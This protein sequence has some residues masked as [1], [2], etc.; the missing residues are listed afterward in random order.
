VA[1][2]ALAAV[3]GIGL[4]VRQRTRA[5]AT[6]A[7]AA[8]ASAG[9]RVVPVSVTTVARRD[10]PIFLEG[11]GSVAA[12]NTVTL[13]AQV[14]GRI[15]KVLFKE[16][17]TVKKGDVLVQLDARPFAIQ[18]QLARANRAR[19]AATLANARL[20]LERNKKL[21]EGGVGSQQAV[22]DATAAVAQG[23]A[24][25]G[26][27][28]AAI[29]SA[30]LNVEYA[31]VVAPIDG[32][33]GLRLIDAGNLVHPSDATGLLVITQ[34]DPIA[35]LFT[36]PEDDLPRVNKAIATAPQRAQLDV[37]AYGRDGVTKLGVGKLAVVDNQINSATAT[38]RLKAIFP[39][40]DRQLWPNQ[41]VKARLSLAARKGALVVPSSVV[42]RGPQ[43]AYAYVVNADDTVALRP[44]EV[45]STQGETSIIGK[46]L[47][48]GERVVVDGQNQLRPGAKIAA[49]PFSGAA[50]G[51]ASGRPG[52][53]A[54][55]AAPAS[56]S[57]SAP[58]SASASG[59][60]AASRGRGKRAE[61]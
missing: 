34:V 11:L 8:S 52:G 14:D 13:K 10:L 38:V 3:V 35:V 19:D 2:V 25:L 44:V 17:D 43:G 47:E 40:A 59:S 24:V 58:A 1:I 54:S 9:E 30:A 33:V 57:A 6:A 53:A 26:S 45:D 36:L 46:G 27:D 39:N 29:A 49:K 37:E 51:S 50:A 60:E 48:S 18:G 22:D 15:E 23:A 32:V 4:F 12:F 42:Q 31:R 20:T 7:A 61:P 28:D 16:G 21:L 56:A 5:S 55:A 41:F